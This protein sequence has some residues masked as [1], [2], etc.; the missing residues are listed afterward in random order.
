MNI[1][2]VAD[3]ITGLFPRKIAVNIVHAVSGETVA[4]YKADL[5][6]L[7]ESFNRP[8]VMEINGQAWRVTKADP[9]HMDHVRRRKGLM[10]HVQKAA[11]FQTFK[12]LVPTRAA[13][14][15]VAVVPSIAHDSTLTI[16][17][18]EWRQLEFLPADLQ[19]VVEEEI[20][21]IEAVMQRVP[22]DNALLGY[23]TVHIRERIG[24]TPLRI[25]F[26]NFYQSV[27]GKEKGV[28]R[29]DDHA[30]IE[31]GFFIR[32]EHYVYYGVMEGEDIVQLCLRTFDSADDE[33]SSV[34]E[35]WDLV[36]VDWCG[37]R[38]V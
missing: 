16:T 18:D 24:T 2:K 34:V 12:S 21:L 13:L 6:S 23:D 17:P 38:V 20:L 22:D 36:L 10:L 9:V 1:L 11:Q 7:P 27:K 25:P 28:V 35:G 14:L 31:H 32:S 4:T 30:V 37:G 5:E 8:T 29:L 19:P 3:G 15:P 33:F 26:D